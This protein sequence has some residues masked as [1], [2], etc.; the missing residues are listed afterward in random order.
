MLTF[1]TALVACHQHTYD[2]ENWEKDDTYHWHPMKCEHSDLVEKFEHDINEFNRCTVCG[3][4]GELLY[5]RVDSDVWYTTFENFYNLRNFTITS[6][7]YYSE[8]Y[9]LIE[10]TN[11]AI[12]YVYVDEEINEEMYATVSNGVATVCEVKDGVWCATSETFDYDKWV[13]EQLELSGIVFFSD[14]ISESFDDFYFSEDEGG[15]YRYSIWRNTI[16][17]LT[18]YKVR[19]VDNS[20]HYYSSQYAAAHM[21]FG[22]GTTVIDEVLTLWEID[23]IG[24]TNIDV[25]L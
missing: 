10:V 12:H 2:E 6:T 3:W 7:N 24:T 4:Q 20:L 17:Y 5:D 8:E 15:T 1:T 11:T 22:E 19:F 16:Y 9:K 18:T 25:H 13:L 23:H 14:K 21:I